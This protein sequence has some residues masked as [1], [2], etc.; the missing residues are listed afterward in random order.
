MTI[1]NAGE[2]RFVACMN[3]LHGALHGMGD[4]NAYL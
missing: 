1:T 2:V 4:G 3:V